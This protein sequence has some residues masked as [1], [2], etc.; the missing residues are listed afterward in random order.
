MIEKKSRRLEATFDCLILF[1]TATYLLDFDSI[2]NSFFLCVHSCSG[3]LRPQ[4]YIIILRAVRVHSPLPAIE[5]F[6]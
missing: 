3:G 2:Q 1:L 4:D 5:W 6:T